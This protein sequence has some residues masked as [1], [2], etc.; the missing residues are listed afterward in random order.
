MYS[1][2]TWSFTITGLCIWLLVEYVHI[3]FENAHTHTHTTLT[4]TG[5]QLKVFSL[6]TSRKKSLSENCT[7]HFSTA[8]RDIKMHLYEITMHLQ[9]RMPNWY[10]NLRP[11]TYRSDCLLLVPESGMRPC[12]YRSECLLLVP[13][14]GMRPC[15]YRSDCLPVPESGMRPCTYRSDCLPLVPESGMRPCTYRSECLVLVPESGM[16]P[17]TYRSDCLPL[18]PELGMRPCMQNLNWVQKTTAY[19]VFCFLLALFKSY[20]YTCIV[21]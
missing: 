13:E 3:T 20:V 7:G 6:T 9:V 5:K 4:H 11:C 15:T 17:C 16:R 21:M 8:P 19:I 14:S 10:L 18:V 12:T 2:L 1:G